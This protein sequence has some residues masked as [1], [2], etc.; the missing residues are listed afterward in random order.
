MDNF[1]LCLRWQIN[2]LLLVSTRVLLISKLLLLLMESFNDTNAGH[3]IFL[4]KNN[5]SHSKS[6]TFE[7]QFAKLAKYLGNSRFMFT[8]K[9]QT[10]R[11][12]YH[13]WWHSPPTTT[14]S[15]EMALLLS[16]LLWYF[17]KHTFVSFL[18]VNCSQEENIICY[19][20]SYWTAKNK[21]K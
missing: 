9:S 3:A 1:W 4:G 11:P 12:K 20:V 14:E 18:E 7:V 6:N 5:L 13:V 17:L 2:Y 10:S 15:I 21:Q 19:Q 16:S 8:S